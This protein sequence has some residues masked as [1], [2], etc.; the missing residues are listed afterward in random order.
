MT[1]IHWAGTGLSAI[2]G[3]RRLIGANYSVRVYNRSVDKAQNAIADLGKDTPVQAFDE[4]TLAN[5]LEPGDIVVSMLPGDF[6]VPLAKAALSKGAHFVSS[7][8]ISDEMQAL[9][10][11]AKNKGL[12]LVNE[13][14][15]DP[16][17][18]HSMAHA[19][20]FDYLNS[21]LANPAHKHYFTS[22]CGGLSREP[23]DFKYKF[24][25]SPLGVLR[26]LKSP[27]VSIRDGEDYHVTK[28]WNAIETLPISMPW[29][30]E[31]FEVYPNRDSRPFISQYHFGE[32]WNIQQFVRGTLR[33]AGWKEAWQPIFDR[34]EQG[35]SDEELAELSDELWQKYALAEGEADRVVLAVSLRVENGYD[36]VWH[37][38][39]LLDAYGNEQGS[40]MARLVSL[41]VSLA[42]ECVMSGDIAAGV[43]AAPDRPD[44]VERWLN[45]ADQISDHFT[46]V[47]HIY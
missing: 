30:A 41:P 27:S 31:A 1:T 13:V 37:Q 5:N 8:Y 14:G 23:N 15:L 3:L 22:Y 21:G 34:I 43:S 39:Y 20:V 35:I 46:P 12:S 6:H 19:L 24:S 47:D 33:Y 9:D 10:A 26:A 32:D 42:V 11:D 36:K 17:I 40:A 7:S 2:P 28:P 38:S 25:W 4:A 44:L 16:G 29:G 45:T 18:D